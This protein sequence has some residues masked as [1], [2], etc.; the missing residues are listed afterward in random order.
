MLQLKL[1]HSTSSDSIISYT[2]LIFSPSPLIPYPIRTPP[3]HP[4]RLYT[5][6]GI[7][8]AV[9]SL[10]DGQAR[11]NQEHTGGSL[12]LS[13]V[14]RHALQNTLPDAASEPWAQRDLLGCDGVIDNSQ[15]GRL[16]D[17]G[18]LRSLL[19]S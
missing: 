9:K 13:H 3:S 5:K 8:A 10:I 7:P 1:H 19:F 2:H 16:S 15:R 6:R 4:S 11:G 17:V 14:R 18:E 12:S